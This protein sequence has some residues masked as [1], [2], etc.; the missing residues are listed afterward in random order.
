L[1]TTYISVPCLFGQRQ[2]FPPSIPA[3]RSPVQPST[4]PSQSKG[5]MKIRVEEGKVTADITET[6]LHSV[7]LELAERTGVIFEVR[8]QDNPLVSIH[9]QHLLLPEAIQRI[10]S[11]SNAIFQFG[12]G[13][14]AAKLALVRVFPRTVPVQQPAIQYLGTGAVT[15]RNALVET[16]EQALQVVVS[17]ASVEDREMAIEMLAKSKSEPGIKALTACVSD[18]APEIRVAAIEG[19][20][21]MGAQAALPEILKSLKDPHPGVR[22]SAATAVALLGSANNV[23]DLRPLIS[24]KDASVATAAEVAIRKLSTFGRK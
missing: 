4:V 19:L 24:D 2:Q 9:L 3:Q 20:A 17:N 15:K 10:V 23:R 13:E 14:E 6:P 12:E 22:Q 11:G 1:V 18:P 16:P 8:G 7:L 21:A 5:F